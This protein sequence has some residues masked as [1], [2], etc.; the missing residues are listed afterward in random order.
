MVRAPTTDDQ[1]GKVIPIC[2]E[3]MNLVSSTSMYRH[4]V[5]MRAVAFSAQSFA[6]KSLIEYE[7]NVS[8]LLIGRVENCGH[9]LKMSPSAIASTRFRQSE[10]LASLSDFLVHLGFTENLGSGG[11]VF[12][13]SKIVSPTQASQEWR[14]ALS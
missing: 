3:V 7:T 2:R 13:D 4:A 12:V 9:D 8:R 6:A 10:R 5:H 11:S 1:I 14:T